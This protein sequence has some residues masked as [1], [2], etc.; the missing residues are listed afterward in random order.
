MIG[1]DIIDLSD[2][3][4]RTRN[5]RTMNMILHPEDCHPTSRQTFWLLWTSKEAIY[6]AHRTTSPFRPKTIKV[7][8]SEV[9]RGHFIFNSDRYHG[10][11]FENKHFI[12]AICTQNIFP[13]FSVYYHPSLMNSQI[14]REKLRPLIAPNQQLVSSNR[15]PSLMPSGR[16]TSISHHGRYGAFAFLSQDSKG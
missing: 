7:A 13:R 1:I 11:I 8:I 10:E 3:L 2:P 9:N 14:I 15:I 12:L 4:L 6:K 5:Q 16:P